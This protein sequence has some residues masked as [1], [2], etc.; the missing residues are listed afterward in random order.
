M[1]NIGRLSTPH[2]YTAFLS[3]STLFFL[4]CSSEPVIT[5][6]EGTFTISIVSMS[7]WGGVPATTPGIEHKVTKLTLHHGGEDWEE[8]RD[9]EEYLRNLQS[10]S[11]SERNWIDIPYHYMIGLDGTIYEARDPKYMGDTN[12]D[13]DPNGHLLTC[14]MGNYENRKPTVEQLEALINLLVWQ[15][16]V[17]DIEPESLKGHRD[18]AETACP[19]RYLYPYVKS[20]FLIRHVKS[21]MGKVIRK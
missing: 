10:W 18:Y 19:G 7:E 17:F 8:G 4:N 5:K 1:N 3:L 20:E 21:R 2:I 11:R 12:T 15:C 9:Q 6:A 14:L 13:Y 16:E